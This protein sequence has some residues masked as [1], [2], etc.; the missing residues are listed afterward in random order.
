MGYILIAIIFTCFGFVLYGFLSSGKISDLEYTIKSLTETVNA[1]QGRLD[2][3]EK[4]SDKSIDIVSD[5]EGE[6]K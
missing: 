3:Y 1:Q 5:S 4:T 6:N 2:F